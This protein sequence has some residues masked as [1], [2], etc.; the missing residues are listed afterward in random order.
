MSTTVFP[1]RLRGALE[2]LGSLTS[3]AASSGMHETYRQPVSRGPAIS[4]GRP[5]HAMRTAPFQVGQGLRDVT[6]HLGSHH[7]EQGPERA[8]Y[9][10]F[11]DHPDPSSGD[12]LEHVVEDDLA[13]RHRAFGHPA[14]SVVHGGDGEG[15]AQIAAL[16]GPASNTR[17]EGAIQPGDLLAHIPLRPAGHVGP[18]FPD[19]SRL[20]LENRFALE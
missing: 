19:L 20:R 18:H 12:R 14:P 8:L 4:L 11:L 2:A 7:A 10:Y 3:G 17:L 13:Q 6:A 15:A 1:A 9:L 5:R 16:L